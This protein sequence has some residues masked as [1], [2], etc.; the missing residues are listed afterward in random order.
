[1]GGRFRTLF[2]FPCNDDLACHPPFSLARHLSRTD[3]GAEL[4]VLR[5]G[6][7]ARESFVRT[8]L[9]WPLLRLM[10]LLVPRAGRWPLRAIEAR[11]AGALREADMAHLYRGC[12]LELMDRLRARGHPVFLERVNTMDHMAKRIIEDAF[13]RTGWP[14]DHHYSEAVLQ[15][16]QAEV[17]AADFVFSPS[18][19]VTASLRERGVPP[20]KILQCSYGWEPTRFETSRCALPAIDGVTV[21]F[22]GGIGIRKGAHLLL[23]AWNRA[24]IRGRLVLAGRMEPLIARHC[25]DELGRPDVVHLPYD[26]DPAPVYRS[27]DL[28]AFPTLEEGSPLVVYEAIGNGLPVVTSPMGAGSIIR[29]GREGLIVEPH[30][31]EGW[32]SALRELATDGEKRRAIGKAARLRAAEFTWDKV[33]HRRYELIKSALSTLRRSR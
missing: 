32:I 1:M 26:P 20:A 9:P 24:G 27:A 18:P 31:Q 3:L 8:P 4:W 22:L 21:L 25:P 12:S 16:Q 15:R 14:P 11:Y 7:R 28:F 30:D 10:R 13:A 23:K 17:D 6:P 2:P 19:L 29:H 33:A 5:R